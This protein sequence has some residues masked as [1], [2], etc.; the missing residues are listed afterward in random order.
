MVRICLYALL[1][2]VGVWLMAVVL[3]QLLEHLHNGD[4]ITKS[5]CD[6]SDSSDIVNT[7]SEVY[8]YSDHWG[9]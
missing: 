6:K 7:L 3:W 5:N 1:M 8:M 9:G 4:S 2:I